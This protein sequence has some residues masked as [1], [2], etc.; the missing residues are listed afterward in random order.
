[1]IHSVHHPYNT[2]RH[3]LPQKSPP[4]KIQGDSY[5]FDTAESENGNQISLIP[6][7][8]KV[9]GIKIKTYVCNKNNVLFSNYNIQYQILNNV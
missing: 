2:G 4:V 8:F 3:P 1:M 6:T 7:N 9:E 5:S